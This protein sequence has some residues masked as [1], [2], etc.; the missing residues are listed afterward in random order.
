MSTEIH[1]HTTQFLQRFF[2]VGLTI[3][4]LPDVIGLQFNGGVDG[5]HWSIT[6]FQVDAGK[7]GN[8][9]RARPV[10]NPFVPVWKK[11]KSKPRSNGE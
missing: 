6:R 5:G 3:T 4:A 1:I 8:A 9:A 11:N 10:F 7:Q 2:R